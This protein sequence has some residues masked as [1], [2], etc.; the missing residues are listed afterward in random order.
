M[1]FDPSVQNG[2]HYTDEEDYMRKANQRSE[3]G[4]LGRLVS[5][6]ITCGELGPLFPGI[7]THDF[8]K[9]TSCRY[10]SDRVFKKAS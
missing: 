1:T 7:P 5:K 4:S 10:K 8:N 6:T 9:I 2:L 3:E